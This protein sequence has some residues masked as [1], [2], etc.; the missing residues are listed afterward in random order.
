MSLIWRYIWP[1][2]WTLLGLLLAG[3]ARVSGGCWQRRAGAL[4]VHGGRLAALCQSLPSFMRFDAI[5]IGHVILGHDAGTL[6]TV[7]AHE[8]VHLRQYERWGPLF[9]PAYLAA[10]AWQWLR[11]RHPYRDNPFEREAY[12]SAPL[13]AQPGVCAT[14]AKME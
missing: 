5:T 6:D 4:E 7:R 11:G 3:C 9:V 2:P 13:A 10:S 14:K 12:A 8:Q 1:M